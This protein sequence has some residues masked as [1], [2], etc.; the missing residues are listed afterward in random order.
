[1]NAVKALRESR[2]WTQVQ[3]AGLLGTDSVTIS[4]WERGV[5]R[6]RR[7]AQARLRE[8]SRSVPERLGGLVG[9]IGADRA[10]R[11]LR[12]VVLLSWRPSGPRFS[13]DPSPRLAEVERARR[14]QIALKESAQIAVRR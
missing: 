9:A 2:G 7:S 5:S 13:A 11:I 4:R 1:M 6:P 8:L 3:L 10:E 12:R 14:E